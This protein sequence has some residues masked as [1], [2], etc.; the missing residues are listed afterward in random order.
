MKIQRIV[1]LAAGLALVLAIPLAAHHAFSAEFDADRP[2]Q[3]RGKVTKM[4]WINPHAWIHLEVMN[5]DGS[6][7]VWMVEGGTPN[8]LARRGFTKRSLLP[9]TEIVVDGYQAKDGSNK[10]NGRDLT[11][12]DGRKLFMG[13]SGTGAPRDGRDPTEQ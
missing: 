3:L 5:D 13:S 10:A 7:T 2:L 11:F 1:L 8:T 9:G 4:E 6:A 12:P